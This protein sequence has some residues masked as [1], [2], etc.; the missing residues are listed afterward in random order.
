MQPEIERCRSEIAS[1]EV[2]LRSGH[3]D[4]QGLLLALNDWHAELR[5]L[6]RE[7][8]EHYREAA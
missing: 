8:L 5:L 1:I 2:E 4:L 3:R 6:E 7:P